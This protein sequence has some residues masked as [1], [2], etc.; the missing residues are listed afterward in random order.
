[1]RRMPVAFFGSLAMLALVA[2]GCPDPVDPP[3]AGMPMDA[4]VTRDAEPADATP[5][6]ATVPDAALDAGVVDAAPDAAVGPR[7]V[8]AIG[9]APG[10]GTA[11][12]TTYTVTGEI[13]RPSSH[14]RAEGAQHK[15]VGG[16]VG[17]AGR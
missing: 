13:G 15:V 2:M 17:P 1:M 4:T 10:S 6:D 7:K 3:D 11:T 16:V 5:E 8:R 12:S 14:G 9:L